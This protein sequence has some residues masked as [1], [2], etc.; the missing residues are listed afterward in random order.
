MV[1]IHSLYR[2]P[3]DQFRIWH[4]ESIEHKSWTEAFV[5]DHLMAANL[6]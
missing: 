2:V 1:F 5:F 4:I 3:L 6:F